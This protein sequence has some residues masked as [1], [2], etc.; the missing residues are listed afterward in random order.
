MLHGRY[1]A[2][3]IVGSILVPFLAA[4]LVKLALG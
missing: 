2:Q 1:H 3:K 4:L